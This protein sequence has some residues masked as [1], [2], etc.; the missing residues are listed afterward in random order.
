MAIRIPPSASTVR[1]VK[2]TEVP[3]SAV[4]RRDDGF[5]PAKAPQMDLGLPQL[6]HLPD[7]G[8]ELRK[9]LLGPPYPS[10]PEE[11]AADE[12]RILAAF[13]PALKALPADQQ[14]VLAQVAKLGMSPVD[15]LRGSH[16]VVADGGRLYDEW[17]KLGAVPRVSSHYPGV[18][19]QQ[20][21][22]DLPGVGAL[23]FGKD[24]NGNTWY[25]LE[26]HPVSDAV[27]HGGDFILHV[28]SGF[29]NVGPAG[30]SP[31]SEKSGQELHFDDVK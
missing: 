20:Y 1:P 27:R 15:L 21:E 30:T 4:V 9:L 8:E 6:P 22:I 26:A 29:Q 10:T 25:Q 14:A 24:E 11:T 17:S 5:T 16:A 18:S 13:G 7:L 3:R 2:A 12:A 31:H 23:L 19:T 28:L